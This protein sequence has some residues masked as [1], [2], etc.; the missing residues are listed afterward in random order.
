MDLTSKSPK[1]L[2]QLSCLASAL[3]EELAGIA[4]TDGMRTQLGILV[5]R[6]EQEISLRQDSWWSTLL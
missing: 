1:Q 6:I 5:A 2:D 4:D 3:I